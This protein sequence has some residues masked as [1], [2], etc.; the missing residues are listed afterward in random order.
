MVG[1]WADRGAGVHLVGAVQK[2]L[3]LTPGNHGFRQ[4]PQVQ[5]EQRR[6]CVDVRVTAGRKL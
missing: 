6:H 3:V 1:L 5:F 2:V 4:L